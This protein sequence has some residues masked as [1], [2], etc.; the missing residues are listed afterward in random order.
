[1]CLLDENLYANVRPVSV[2]TIVGISKAGIDVTTGKGVI[3]I[4]E[5]QSSSSKKMSA[6]DYLNGH[7]MKNGMV[8]GE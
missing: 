5:L 1:T 6:A 2:G 4:T 8:F 3:R 7:H